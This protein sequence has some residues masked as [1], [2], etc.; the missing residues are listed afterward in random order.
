MA[1]VDEVQSGVSDQGQVSAARSRRAEKPW[2]SLRRPLLIERLHA[3][4]LLW[5]QK[6]EYGNG[7]VAFLDQKYCA[8]VYVKMM[9]D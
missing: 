5:M 6:L 9:E 3:A 4:A 1:W 2:T 8:S 7:F